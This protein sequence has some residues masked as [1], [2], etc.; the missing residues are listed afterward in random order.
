MPRS[1]L[2]A[3][4]L[5]Y[6]WQAECLCKPGVLEGANIVYCAPTSGG[7][8]MVA[9]ILGLR[10]LADTHKCFMLV[11][12][13]VALCEEKVWSKCGGARVGNPTLQAARLEP[14]LAA[15]GETVKL[16]NN[17]YDGPNPKP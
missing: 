7:K 2:E 14:T 6:A 5:L 10:R 17:F 11:L 4:H 3:A 16:R 1:C 13:Y 15:I 8:S 9:E 12:P